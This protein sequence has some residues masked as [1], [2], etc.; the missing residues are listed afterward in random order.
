MLDL[1]CSALETA[2]VAS[3]GLISLLAVSR[4]K[5]PRTIGVPGNTEARIKIATQSLCSTH[6]PA[7]LTNRDN[8]HPTA[9][10]NVTIQSALM[11]Y[12]AR[13]FIL[14][15]LRLC[16]LTAQFREL[17]G[18]DLPGFHQTHYEIFR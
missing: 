14:V 4:T 3:A 11:A 9:K 8:T 1:A 10:N 7:L 17:G 13:L 6:G 15:I 16:N 2:K 5:Y 12:E 18:I